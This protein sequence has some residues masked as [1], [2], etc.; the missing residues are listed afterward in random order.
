MSSLELKRTHL[1]GCP[2]S[3]LLDLVSQSRVPLCLLRGTRCLLRG[4]RSLKFLPPLSP[5]LGRCRPS[6]ILVVENR[7]IHA[8]PEDQ[9]PL[10]RG[11]HMRVQVRMIGVRY[12]LERIIARPCRNV[13]PLANASVRLVCVPRDTIHRKRWTYQLLC[14]ARRFVPGRIES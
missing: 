2:C 6:F 10:A 12:V 13:R 9:D 14:L 8:L 4:T 11:D 5:L 1:L 7:G 3:Q